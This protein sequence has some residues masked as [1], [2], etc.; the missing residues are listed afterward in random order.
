[1]D[2][3]KALQKLIEL[4]WENGFKGAK[5]HN[6]EVVSLSAILLADCSC[7]LMRATPI[8]SPIAYGL[9]FNHDF[10]KALCSAK[11][12]EKAGEIVEQEMFNS[13]DIW[14]HWQ[15]HIMLAVISEDPVMYLAEEFLTE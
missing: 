7:A 6:P 11:Y 8:G 15:L 14:R 12:G 5:N 2:K 13:Y 4:A 9:L 1:M 10:I 3:Q